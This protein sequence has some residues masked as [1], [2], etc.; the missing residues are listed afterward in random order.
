MVRERWS[1]GSLGVSRPISDV[2][3]IIFLQVLYSSAH[4]SDSFPITVKLTFS[5]FKSF[6]GAGIPTGCL[7]FFDSVRISL[8]NRERSII[9]PAFFKVTVLF[10][11]FSFEGLLLEYFFS[12]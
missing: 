6:S 10:L 5:V 9:F 2:W 3:I 11:R 4:R 12:H 1:I 8:F 7:Q